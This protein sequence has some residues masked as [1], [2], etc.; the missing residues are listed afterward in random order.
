LREYGKKA[1]AAYVGMRVN[2]METRVL[3]INMSAV[4][5]SASVAP[6]MAKSILSGNESRG[7]G[8]IRWDI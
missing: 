3:R 1:M 8:G 7:G 5:G 2:D 4:V 6:F